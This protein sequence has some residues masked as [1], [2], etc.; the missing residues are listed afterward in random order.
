MVSWADGD[1]AQYGELP[2]EQPVTI[3]ANSVQGFLVHSNDLYGLVQSVGIGSGGEMEVWGEGGEEEG[4]LP[5]MAG[6]IVCEDASITLLAG[7][8]IGHNVFQD[9]EGLAMP[10]AGGF[11][12]YIDYTVE[13]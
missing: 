11:V 4:Q 7:L 8:A 12:G 5:F 10:T 1:S 6:D 3:P 2:L 9:L 13:Q